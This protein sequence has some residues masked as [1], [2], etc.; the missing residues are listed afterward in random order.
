MLPPGSGTKAS[1]LSCEANEVTSRLAGLSV[2]TTEAS[3]CRCA[4]A[5]ES[6]ESAVAS[7]P[8]TVGRLGSEPARSTSL[9]RSRA[10]SATAATVADSNEPEV[11]GTSPP[12]LQQTEE[13]KEATSGRGRRPRDVPSRWSTA[14][15]RERNQKLLKGPGEQHELRKV[16]LTQMLR[17]RTQELEAILGGRRDKGVIYRQM[18]WQLAA[19]IPPFGR[20]SKSTMQMCWSRLPTHARAPRCSS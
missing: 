8:A 10:S 15:L 3:D 19:G 20:R 11:V 17:T 14:E 18:G 4:S 13:T 16:A 6:A 5:A 9:A 2:D 12:K 7:R 1:V